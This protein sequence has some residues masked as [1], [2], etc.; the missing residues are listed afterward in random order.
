M[1]M[2]EAAGF[3]GSKGRS[4]V[5]ITYNGVK[6]LQADVWAYHAYDIANDFYA[7]L[8][9]K[10]P[11]AKGMAVKLNAQYLMQKDTGDSLAG[12]IDFNMLG[13]KASIG[14]KKW[15]AYAAFNSSG[16][17]DN[18]TEGQYFNAWGADPAYTSS[19]FSRNAYRED[20]DAYKI[21]ARYT[22]M[23][24]LKLMISYADY[25]KSK[26][27]QA[28]LMASPGTNLHNDAYEVDTV[29]VYKPS[30]KW[31]FKLFNARRKSE[32]NDNTSAAT[33]GARQ[34][35]YRLI[36]SYTF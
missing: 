14:T 25:G 26:T 16:D 8:K 17:K 35:H 13:L 34:N 21:G 18:G 29:L 1:S 24:G 36:A 11:V 9:Y 28:N 23:K 6:N 4:V 2:S 22:I 3:G 31:M 12:D 7:E 19:I 10:I 15:G 30:K 33:E 27:Q 5:G 20:V 32:Y